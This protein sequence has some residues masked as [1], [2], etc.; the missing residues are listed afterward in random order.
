MLKLS[1]RVEYALIALRHLNQQDEKNLTTAKFLA[2]TYGIPKELLAKILQSLAKEN[3]LKAVKGPQGGYRLCIDPQS[4]NM[5]N[6]FEIIE[7][8]IGIVNCYDET[9]C[10]QIG[11]CTIK[12]PIDR[13][14]D[15]MRDMFNN[16]TLADIT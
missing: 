15:S 5:T 3:I 12:A 14:N 9:G 16:M 10:E 2:N 7:G 4:V 11:N 13:I 8:P 6:L 1:R